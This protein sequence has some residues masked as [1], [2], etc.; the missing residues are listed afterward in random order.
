[1]GKVQVH[2]PVL[3][4]EVVTSFEGLNNGV[5]VDATLGMGGHTREILEQIPNS[6]IIGIDLDSEAVMLARQN[7]KNFG[8]RVN[9]AQGNYVDM[10]QIARNFN[11][12]NVDGVLLDLG[13]SSVQIDDA[14]RG[15]SFKFDSELDMR[16]DKTKGVSASD[17]LN[18]LDEAELSDMFYTYGEERQ[19]R[20]IAKSIV[21]SRPVKTT[22][23]LTEI[24]SNIKRKSKSKIHPSTK[25]FQALRIYVNQE[26]KNVE[27]GLEEAMKLLKFG[28]KISVISYHSLEDRIVKNFLRKNS[29]DCICPVSMIECQCNHTAT[30]KIVNKKVIKPTEKEIKNNP[31]SRSAKLRIAQRIPLAEIV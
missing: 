31:R 25:V 8:N 28:G 9:I 23:E 26:L 3:L 27:K 14:N 6:S 10:V 24:I 30:I 15:F 18:S 2:I 21:K 20:I 4:K 7:L 19:S 11:E 1:M 16:F 29:I 13:F 5:F 17:V 22:Y 12:L